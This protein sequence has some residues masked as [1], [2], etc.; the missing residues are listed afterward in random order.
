ME[1]RKNSDAH[2]STGRPCRVPDICACRCGRR[3]GGANSC[4]VGCAASAAIR[5]VWRRGA[6][7][8]GTAKEQQE[9]QRRGGR[10][11]CGGREGEAGEWRY[12]KERMMPGT[13]ND[14]EERSWHRKVGPIRDDWGV[15]H[16]CLSR[17]ALLSCKT[18]GNHYPSQSVE[19]RSTSPIARLHIHVETRHRRRPVS[20][21]SSPHPASEAPFTQR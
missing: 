3:T 16:S 17:G 21:S 11:I 19:L 14:K 6:D 13:K 15:T 12:I 9:G 2:L 20:P 1:S 5:R 7:V 10:G 18:F 8:H 4:F